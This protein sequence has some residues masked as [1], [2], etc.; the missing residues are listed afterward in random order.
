M[1]FLSS[2]PLDLGGPGVPHITGL[3]TPAVGQQQLEAGVVILRGGPG[4][5]GLVMGQ[6]VGRGGRA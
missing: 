1:G 5:L 4:D 3:H 2:D 6:L